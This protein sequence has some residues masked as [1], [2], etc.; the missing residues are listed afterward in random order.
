MR[1]EP[2]TARWTYLEFVWSLHRNKSSDVEILLN[3]NR[4]NIA[5]RVKVEV[6]RCILVFFGIWG[7]MLRV[8][9]VYAPTDKKRRVE[10]FKN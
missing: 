9:C 7:I 4:I 6:G 2:N 10:L 3:N 8:F 5:R 1:E